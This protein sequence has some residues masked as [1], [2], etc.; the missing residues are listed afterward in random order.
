MIFN[1]LEY[2]FATMDTTNSRKVLKTSGLACEKLADICGYYKI[3]GREK[4]MD[5]HVDLEEVII[6]P[7]YG[8]MKA[9]C[10]KKKLVWHMAWVKR[11]DEHHLRTAAKKSYTFYEMF[12]RTVDMRKCL[13]REYIEGSTHKE[14]G[15]GKH[16]RK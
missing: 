4:D 5:S 2:K 16:H 8:G 10:D 9:E 6:D 15:G 13:Q 14:S 3:W 1:N 12:R 11:L 7:Y